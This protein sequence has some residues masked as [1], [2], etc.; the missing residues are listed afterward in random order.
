[1]GCWV[2]AADPDPEGRLG[3]AR[4]FLE[5]L[6]LMVELV[7]IGLNIIGGGAVEAGVCSSGA[8]SLLPETDTVLDTLNTT[9]QSSEQDK[10]STQEQSL[11]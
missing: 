6:D 7:V 3:R 2:R 8:E 11:T 5:A 4:G 9:S 1:M 10:Y